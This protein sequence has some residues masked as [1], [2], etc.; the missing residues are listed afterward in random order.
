ML[1]L[2]STNE[3]KAIILP[4][5]YFVCYCV[6][7]FCY[8]AKNKSSRRTGNG[9]NANLDGVFFSHL[10]HRTGVYV[11]LELFAEVLD[12]LLAFTHPTR[13]LSHQRILP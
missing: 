1:D 4:P 3:I 10:K 6:G 5:F 11:A 7:Q 9:K 13:S 2:L 8:S 12:K